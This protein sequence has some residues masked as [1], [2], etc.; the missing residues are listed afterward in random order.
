MRRSRGEAIVRRLN[1]LG[2]RITFDDVLAQAGGGAL[3]RPHIARALVNDGWA[4][5]LRD[6]FDRYLGNGRAAYVPKERLAISE[7][8][9][10][11]HDAGGLAILAH[12]GQ[13]GSRKRIESLVGAGLDGVEVRH[14]SH[15]SEDA[16]RLAALVEH[17]GLVPSG[18]SDWHG[19]SEGNRVLGG[20]RIPAAW[21][22]RQDRRVAERTARRGDDQ[23]AC[24]A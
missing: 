13:S 7:A 4:T 11:I 22:D 10:I 8:I 24:V 15:S 2:V 19:L 9:A 16:A 18:G 17:F 5:D 12:P 6:A 20:M 21:L 1:E 3:G 14:P 23:A